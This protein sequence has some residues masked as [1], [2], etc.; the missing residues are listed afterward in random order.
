[1]IKWHLGGAVP[2]LERLLDITP[3]RG[4]VQELARL[5]FQGLREIGHLELGVTEGAILAHGPHLSYADMEVVE[6]ALLTLVRC[7]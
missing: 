6:R 4:L 2:K 1:M 7:W 3:A 5:G